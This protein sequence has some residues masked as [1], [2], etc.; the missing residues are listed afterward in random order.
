MRKDVW[1]SA[2][3][4]LELVVVKERGR[5]QSKK[6]GGK[7]HSRRGAVGLKYALT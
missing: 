3:R 2:R 7:S 4:E 5:V 6:R 1:S